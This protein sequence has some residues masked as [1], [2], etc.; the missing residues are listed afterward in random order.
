MRRRLGLGLV[1]VVGASLSGCGLVHDDAQALLARGR[2]V[3]A[4][5]ELVAR[6]GSARRG[7]TCGFLRYAIDRGVTHLA[8]GDLPQGSAWIESAEDGALRAPT[9]LS[10]SDRGRLASA[11]ASLPPR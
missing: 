3:E 7:S 4:L 6:E 8:L 1:L 11:L 5:E 9:C 10:S 2:P